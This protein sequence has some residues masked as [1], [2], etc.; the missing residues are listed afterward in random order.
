M[1]A[2]HR[3]CSFIF[4]ALIVEGDL[5]VGINTAGKAPAVSSALR[6]FLTSK[7]PAGIHDLIDRVHCIRQSE[8][9]GKPRQEKIVQICRDFFKL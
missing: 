2:T 7:I 4:P 9:M 6:K 1:Q 8:P 3:K 5:C